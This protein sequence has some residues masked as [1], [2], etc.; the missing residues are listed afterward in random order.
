MLAFC[1]RMVDTHQNVPETAFVTVG[2]CNCRINNCQSFPL[3]SNFVT[4]KNTTTKSIMSGLRFSR[5]AVLAG[6]LL[7]S[8]SV[9]VAQCYHRHLS[10]RAWW[11]SSKCSSDKP[12]PLKE[13]NNSSA[14]FLVSRRP[15]ARVARKQSCSE[16][17]VVEH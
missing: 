5:L 16:K 9:D 4:E 2:S 17:S 10:R 1:F 13:N 8:F 14:A 11:T 6:L 15:K 7:A 12:A 3:V